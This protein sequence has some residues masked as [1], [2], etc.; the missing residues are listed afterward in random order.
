MINWFSL[1]FK[2]PKEYSNPWNI[3]NLMFFLGDT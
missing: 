1:Q 2:K 3:I